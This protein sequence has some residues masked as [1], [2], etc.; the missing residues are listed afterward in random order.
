MERIP[1][2][3]YTQELREEAVKL[4]SS[5]NSAS[6]KTRFFATSVLTPFSRNHT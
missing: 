1:R 5:S 6:D 2:G 3:R 4:V